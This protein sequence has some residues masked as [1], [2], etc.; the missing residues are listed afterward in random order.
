ML[1]ILS[2]FLM[3]TLWY[4]CTLSVLHCAKLHLLWQ[5]AAWMPRELK[6]VIRWTSLF[7]LQKY[8]NNHQHLKI[9]AFCSI[10]FGWVQVVAVG[11]VLLGCSFAKS[12]ITI[13]HNAASVD[14][15]GVKKWGSHF[16][17]EQDL[18]SRTQLTFETQAYIKSQQ[19][20]VCAHLV[21]E[22]VF[23][24]ITMLIVEG[25]VILSPAWSM[26]TNQVNVAS[27][28]CSEGSHRVSYWWNLVQQKTCHGSSLRLEFWFWLIVITSLPLGPYSTIEY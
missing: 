9:A 27:L 24:D 6:N 11:F 28:L 26:L 2:K 5:W 7:C 8:S 10:W 17:D 1:Q 19:N 15:N 4:W 3:Q 12:S 13:L 25:E 18:I 23:N 14:A 16:G 22:D 21:K 20:L